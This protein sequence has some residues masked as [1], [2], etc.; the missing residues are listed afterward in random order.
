MT[1]THHKR[2][3]Y[4]DPKEK[5]NFKSILEEDEMDQ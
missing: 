2:L 4:P 5:C 3:A 1:K